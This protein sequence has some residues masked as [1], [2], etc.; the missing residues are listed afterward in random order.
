MHAATAIERQSV[1]WKRSEPAAVR[2]W[3]RAYLAY[4]KCLAAALDAPKQLSLGGTKVFAGE[5]FGGSPSLGLGI[6]V[7]QP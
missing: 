7:M 6:A 3:L 5:C 4:V 2:A 1:Y